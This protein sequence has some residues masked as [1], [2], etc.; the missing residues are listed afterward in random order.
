M[1]LRMFNYII[2][3]APIK[4]GS[5]GKFFSELSANLFGINQAVREMMACHNI[6]QEVPRGK[7][8]V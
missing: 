6:H 8:G 7:G 4:I 5:V 3:S 1:V 2:G